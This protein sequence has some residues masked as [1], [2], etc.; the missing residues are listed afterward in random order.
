V[1]RFH[2]NLLGEKG[3]DERKLIINLIFRIGIQDDVNGLGWK[4]QS[5]F[6]AGSG[7]DSASGLCLRGL[8]GPVS[9]LIDGIRGNRHD[10]HTRYVV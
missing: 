9:D 7:E 5:L 4:L 2:N 3:I 1:N 8:R 10:K 6:S